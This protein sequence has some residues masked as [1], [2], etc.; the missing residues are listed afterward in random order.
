M[1][2][3]RISCDKNLGG[4]RDLVIRSNIAS[5]S[6]SE[7]FTCNNAQQNSYS[8]RNLAT[9]HSDYS[10]RIV[11]YVVTVGNCWQHSDN[12]RS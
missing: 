6:S 2:E 8:I 5:E 10:V 9:L 3:Q 4:M 12:T 11:V 7:F 1:V